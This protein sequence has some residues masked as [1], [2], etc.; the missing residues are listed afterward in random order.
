MAQI[1]QVSIC[2][3]TKCCSVFSLKVVVVNGEVGRCGIPS[4]VARARP[5][6]L[7]S[8]VIRH[9][10]ASSQSDASRLADSDATVTVTRKKN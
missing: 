8:G 5:A 6:P 7:W 10:T 4:L 9:K 2:L 3:T 1:F